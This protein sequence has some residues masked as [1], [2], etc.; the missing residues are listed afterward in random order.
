MDFVNCIRTNKE[1]SVNPPE[2]S[3]RSLQIALAE[4]EKLPIAEEETCECFKTTQKDE[5]YGYWIKCECG[6]FTTEGSK[7]CPDCGKKI[8]IVGEKDYSFSLED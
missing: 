4:I 2:D 7:Y 1:S 3:F 5:Y 8:K 6:G